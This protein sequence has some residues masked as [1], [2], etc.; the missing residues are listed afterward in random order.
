[1]NRRAVVRPA[2]TTLPDVANHIELTGAF[3]AP[4]RRNEDV[5]VCRAV[6]TPPWILPF[7]LVVLVFVLGVI[8]FIG[9]HNGAPGVFFLS[10]GAAAV[11]CT[12]GQI[13]E[14]RRHLA[15]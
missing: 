13:A 10:I 11:G 7:L 3:T 9:Q 1:M 6:T 8:V 14:R 12:I 4:H 5:L 15:K 2:R